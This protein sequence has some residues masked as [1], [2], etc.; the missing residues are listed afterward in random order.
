MHMRRTT[1]VS[2]SLHS[3]LRFKRSMDG[4]AWYTPPYLPP[5]SDGSVYHCWRWGIDAIKIQ[6]FFSSLSFSLSTVSCC[7]YL[8][9]WRKSGVVCGGGRSKIGC[10]MRDWLRFW[11]LKRKM[12]NNDWERENEF[13]FLYFCLFEYM[14]VSC[15][16]RECGDFFCFN[17]FFKSVW[18]SQTKCV[19]LFL[20]GI[21][22]FGGVVL[23][24]YEVITTFFYSLKR[25]LSPLISTPIYYFLDFSKTS[26][27][28]YK[29]RI[30][31][32]KIPFFL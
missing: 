27:T 13:F 3:L 15:W 8:Q 6:L 5:Y 19:R 17:D 23:R 26:T 25:L 1:T 21:L 31:F 11:C 16:V 22:F 18:W 10:L 24:E 30:I 12:M 7:C 2:E 28:F 4:P 29:P 14:C 9:P 20:R 32:L